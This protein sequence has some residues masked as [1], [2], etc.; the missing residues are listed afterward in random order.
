MRV[1]AIQLLQT[2][3]EGLDRFCTLLQYSLG[4]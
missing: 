4:V 3:Y 1:C 2:D